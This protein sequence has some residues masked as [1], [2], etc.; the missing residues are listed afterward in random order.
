MNSPVQFLTSGPNTTNRFAL[1]SVSEL[2]PAPQNAR[3]HSL[4]Q[5]RKLAESIKTF[6]F[7][8]PVLADR[9]NNI[10]AG[11]GRVLAAQMLGLSQ[12]PVISLDHL[13]EQQARAY[14]L[15][16]NKLTDLSDWDDKKLAV[17]LKDLSEMALDFEIEAIGFDPPE[18]DFRIQSLEEPTPGD[19]VD[20]F[21][22]A[23]PDPVSAV[24]DIWQLGEHR[25]Y[26]GS[27]LDSAAYSKLL[28]GEL[29]A[30]AFTDPP[31][32]VRIDGHVSGKGAVQHREFPMATGEMSNSEFRS[33][34]TS[35][36]AAINRY[37]AAGALIYCCMDWRHMTEM[38][39]AGRSSGSELL[40]LCVWVKTNG[41]MGSL[42]RSRHE[43]VFLFKNGS[44]S[45]Q[46]NVQLGRFGRNR[47]NV[48]NYAGA[49]SFGRKGFGRGIE[50]HPTVKPVLMVADAIL[51]CT[52]RHEIVLDPFFG[53]GTTL[54]AAERT[55]R[56]C[57]GIELDPIYVDTAIERW[58][59]MT[60][61]KAASPLGETYDFIKA[62][63]R[64]TNE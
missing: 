4:S 54:L 25:L 40:N 55:G 56:R 34:L 21:S 49:N 12:V 29:A 46:N 33:F 13:S 52:K 59:R 45:H 11:H 8:A 2:R 28:H 61:R 41:G 57:Y 31:Y 3:K 6:G 37:T 39:D 27:A 24:G 38:L 50:L 58:Q 5:L 62:K 17:Q 30:A 16:D 23:L 22:V 63:R 44:A 60:G 32:N 1:V 9:D 35:A 64:P 19:D 36:M 42:Y 10:L 7:N 14:M 47:T 48:W 26:C 20:G 15:A 51:D 18:I 43:L 53:S